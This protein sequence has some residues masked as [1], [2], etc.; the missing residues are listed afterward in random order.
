M[1]ILSKI[2]GLILTSTSTP[3]TGRRLLYAKSDGWYDKNSAGVETKVVSGAVADAAKAY[4]AI[5]T[6]TGTDAPTAQVFG[7]NDIGAIVWAR[8]AEGVY[9]GTLVGAFT[10]NK[11]A[12]HVTVGG[13]STA[14]TA[15]ATRT[16]ADVVTISTFDDGFV[17][18]DLEGTLYVNIQVWP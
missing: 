4:D 15:Q 12:I 14:F 11:T 10:A 17:P 2:Q 16:S 18:D 1:T 5:L 6:Q 13:G 8:S 9:T 7:T 3:A